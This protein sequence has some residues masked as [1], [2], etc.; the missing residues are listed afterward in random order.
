MIICFSTDK[1]HHSRVKQN[2][3]IEAGVGLLCEN[4]NLT[5]NVWD[6]INPLRLVIF[7]SLHVFVLPF[8]APSPL[9]L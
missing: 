2:L 3:E 7:F 6:L 8:I 1:I 4:F 5:H 9:Q